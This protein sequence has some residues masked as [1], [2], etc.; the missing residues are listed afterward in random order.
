MIRAMISSPG[1]NSG[2]RA[3]V[4][5]FGTSG[6]N[7]IYFSVTVVN[8]IADAGTGSHCGMGKASAL[9]VELSIIVDEIPHRDKPV[10]TELVLNAFNI[11]LTRFSDHL[12][13]LL[14]LQ[15]AP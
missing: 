6:D 5:V 11:L 8:V 4:I 10:R 3:V 9:P 1:F 2:D 13:T 7:I 15:Q 12:Q 14:S